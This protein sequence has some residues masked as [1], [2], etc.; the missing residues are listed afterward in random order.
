MSYYARY[1]RQT[2]IFLTAGIALILTAILVNELLGRTFS[3]PVMVL[4]GIGVI[5]LVI[6]GSGSTPHG[7][8]K[9]FASLL[10]SEPTTVNAREFITALNMVGSVALVKSSRRLVEGAVSAYEQSDEAEE[11]I[12][13]ELRSAVEKNIKKKAF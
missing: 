7:I 1:I 13:K 12:V 9:A 6:G 5:P 10:Q 4:F 2:R 11:D 3:L 8:V